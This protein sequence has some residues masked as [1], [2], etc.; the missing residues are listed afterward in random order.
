VHV[1]T[2]ELLTTSEL[3]LTRG[4]TRQA[5]AAAVKRGALEPAMV[6]GN[7]YYLFTPDEQPADE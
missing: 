1:H 3:A 6:L 5:I 4:V 7:G 2:N